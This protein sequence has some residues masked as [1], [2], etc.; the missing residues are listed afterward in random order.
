MKWLLA[1]LVVG[2]VS[3]KVSSRSDE[4]KLLNSTYDYVIVGGGTSGLTVANRLSDGGKRMC[5]IVSF[6][7][8]SDLILLVIHIKLYPLPSSCPSPTPKKPHITPS[9]LTSLTR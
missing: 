4:A 3:A 6:T 9:N 8:N 7:S 2:A 5:Q 1:S